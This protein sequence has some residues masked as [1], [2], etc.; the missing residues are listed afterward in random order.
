MLQ[1]FFRIL[2]RYFMVPVFRSGLGPLFG[3][4][5]SGYIMVIRTVGRKTGR[6]RYVP[7][8]YAIANGSV[9]CLAGFGRASDWYRNIMAAPNVGLILPGGAVAGHAEEV[10]EPDERLDVTRQIMKNAGFMGFAEGFNPFTVSDEALREKTANMPVLRIR[11]VGLA[12]GASDPG[13]YAWV[14]A[15]VLTALSVVLPRTILRNRRG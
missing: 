10:E 13:G 4:P 14:W 9:Y 15:V 7:V 1:R 3:N 12:A 8:N 5:L 2:N 6:T 11:P